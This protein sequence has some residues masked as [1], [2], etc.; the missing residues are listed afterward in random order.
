[1]QNTICK[2]R[3]VFSKHC[4]LRYTWGH[5][6]VTKQV[7]E[8]KLSFQKLLAMRAQPMF[9]QT[10]RISL[11]P[12]TWSREETATLLAHSY[13][14]RGKYITRRKSSV[15]FKQNQLL[16]SISQRTST[17]TVIM[18]LLH[19]THGRSVSLMHNAVQ[20]NIYNWQTHSLLTVCSLPTVSGPPCWGGERT[21]RAS[22]HSEY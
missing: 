14:Y 17:K 22:G 19:Y 20:N 15:P 9:D 3:S 2:I 1:M 4:H 21:G 7:T 18:F 13:R 12:H 16:H 6:S 8:D 10:K 5:M 11:K